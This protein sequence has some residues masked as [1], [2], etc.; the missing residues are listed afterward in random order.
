MTEILSYSGGTHGPGRRHRNTPPTL[1]VVHTNEPGP[2]EPSGAAVGLAKYLE[3][4]HPPDYPAY[5]ALTD[6]VQIVVTAHDDE[7]VNGAGGTAEYAL[8]V[9]I[10]GT[11]AQT[12]EQWDDA[13]SR[14]AVQHA[15]A[16]VTTWCARH[17]IP[18]RK[19]NGRESQNGHGICGHGDVSSWSSGSG[20]HSDPGPHF[21][22]DRF[23]TLVKDGHDT[24][25]PA[26]QEDFDVKHHLIQSNNNDPRIWETDGFSGKRWI[27]EA[28]M[29]IVLER[30]VENG[31]DATTKKYHPGYAESLPTIGYAPTWS[32]EK[33]LQS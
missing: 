2:H 15:A 24:A 19:L 16:V 22:W 33:G 29:P 7:R 13:F 32:K 25:A 12:A 21:P 10:Y 14:A 3:Q 23:I 30:F 11:A 17:G 28:E 9:C 31:W 27:A 1:I 6:D 26:A 18:I 20:G 4:P 5:H 8:H